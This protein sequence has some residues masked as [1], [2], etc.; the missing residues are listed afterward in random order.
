[1]RTYEH[2]VRFKASAVIKL[3][4]NPYRKLH[5][6]CTGVWVKLGVKNSPLQKTKRCYSKRRIAGYITIATVQVTDKKTSKDGWLFPD[7]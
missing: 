3:K 4:Q 5:N 7:A 1:M 2:G 6:S